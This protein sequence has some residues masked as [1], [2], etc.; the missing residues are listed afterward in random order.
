MIILLSFLTF[1]FLKQLSFAKKRNQA[2]TTE[3]DQRILLEQKVQRLQEEVARDFHDEIGNKIA[4]MIGLSNLIK[5]KNNIEGQR[6]EK[7]TLLSKDI[8]ETAKDFIW[9]LS[10]KNN[11]LDSLCKYLR[12]YGENFF[13]LFST[14]D[15][16]YYESSLQSFDISYKKSRNLILAYKEIL[17]NIIKHAQATKVI[18]TI[19]QHQ[20]LLVITIQDNGIGFNENSVN[21][22]N[23]L[24]NIKA[25]IKLVNATLYLNSTQGVTY[26]I[27]LPVDAI[28]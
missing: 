26:K 1:L 19:D 11:N 21:F 7:I 3:I 6:I 14:I 9:S 25:R 13:D 5:G 27:T 2:L 22:G 18:L 24:L 15:F 20:E 4:S 10:P 28:N 17:S 23:G 12:D 16:L 8:Y